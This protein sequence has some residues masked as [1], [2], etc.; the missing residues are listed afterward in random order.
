MPVRSL[1]K[2]LADPVHE[3]AMGIAIVL[4]LEPHPSRGIAKIAINAEHTAKRD[5]GA[6][7]LTLDIRMRGANQRALGL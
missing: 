4:Q 7:W 2:N 5:G 1:G 3:R 6:S